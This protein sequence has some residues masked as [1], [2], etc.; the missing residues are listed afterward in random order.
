MNQSSSSFDN[1]PWDTDLLYNLEKLD[2]IAHSVA[3]SVKHGKHPS[4]NL[5]FNSEFKQ[6]THFKDGDDSRHLDWRVYARTKKKYTRQYYAET[7]TN[8]CFFVDTSLSMDYTSSSEIP[9]KFQAAQ[10]IIA[11]LSRLFNNQQDTVLICSEKEDSQIREKTKYSRNF[12]H[13]L[14]HIL[15]LKCIPNNDILPLMESSLDSIKKHS[16]VFILS[17][18][19][20]DLNNLSNL[21]RKMLSISKNLQFVQILDPMELTMNLPQNTD[22]NSRIRM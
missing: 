21:T 13:I 14:A 19:L 9:S 18:F 22:S 6:F 3:E 16:I 8:V 20:F 4:Q 11:I 15:K 17:D 10:V 5:G 1:I 2:W 12:N 7:T